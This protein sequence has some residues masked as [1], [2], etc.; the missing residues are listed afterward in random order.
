MN[1]EYVGTAK[2]TQ[3]LEWLEK[4]QEEA[5]FATKER[6]ETLKGYVSDYGKGYTD[7]LTRARFVMTEKIK[8]ILS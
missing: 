1:P 4:W 2:L 6:D 3:L 7:G 5:D 8:E